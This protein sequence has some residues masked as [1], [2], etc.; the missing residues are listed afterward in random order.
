MRLLLTLRADS[1]THILKSK[2]DLVKIINQDIHNERLRSLELE[3]DIS[4]L[5]H[6]R[7]VAIKRKQELET[8]K[9]QKLQEK[10]Q[11]EHDAQVQKYLYD[12]YKKDELHKHQRALL[13]MKLE[14][15]KSSF[16]QEMENKKELFE[17][18]QRH[19]RHKLAEKRKLAIQEA[20]L[21]REQFEGQ[22]KNDLF[23]AQI[24]KYQWEGMYDD[25]DGQHPRLKHGAH[26]LL[27]A[28][29]DIKHGER[30][31]IEERRRYEMEK[32]IREAQR[33]K[34][35]L[36]HELS[37]YKTLNDPNTDPVMKQLEEE[38]NKAKETYEEMQIMRE[39]SKEHEKLRKEIHDI[40][41][42]TALMKAKDQPED[43]KLIK[44]RDDLLRQ[45]QDLEVKKQWEQRNAR[46]E[47][48]NRKMQRDIAVL[49]AQLRPIDTSVTKR[50]TELAKELAVKRWDMRH[51]VSNTGMERRL[52]EMNAV[53]GHVSQLNQMRASQVGQRHSAPPQEE[54]MYED[55]E[56]KIPYNWDF[57]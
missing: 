34:D 26:Q 11:A 10:L 37:K 35:E 56:D 15:E 27:D 36:S 52:A 47:E 53:Q 55:L 33:K 41:Y 24:R 18:E 44:Q 28:G 1:P 32:L 50:N 14:A 25:P 6:Q 19:N 7:G 30:A 8:I 4:K 5:Q 31:L 29:I 9:R 16:D 49:E 45:M 3:T 22:H 23:L 40:E 39:K 43:D 57:H 12:Q 46:F 51:L 54:D 42:K 17:R 2:N 20:Q 21:R 48:E 13:E 38:L